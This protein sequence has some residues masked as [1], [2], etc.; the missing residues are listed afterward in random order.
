MATSGKAVSDYFEEK[1][2]EI[3]P[4]QSFPETPEPDFTEGGEQ[5]QQQQQQQKEEEATDDSEDD[6]IQ[7]RRKRL[8]A[9]E[10]L[11]HIK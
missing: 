3:Y 8:K 7:P 1:L 9:D 5:Q 4:G 10:K 11:F 2:Q 6:F